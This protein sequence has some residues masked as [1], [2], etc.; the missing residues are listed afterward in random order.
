MDD[1]T[2]K[3]NAQSIS[4]C[5]TGKVIAQIL[6]RRTPE[7]EALAN[8]NYIVRACNH[9]HEVATKNHQMMTD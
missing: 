4:I 1:W 9:Y 8:A 6:L 2:I 7:D 5:W 3:E